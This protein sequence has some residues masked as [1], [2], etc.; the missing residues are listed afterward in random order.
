MVS[1]GACE[2]LLWFCV[3]SASRIRLKWLALQ[4]KHYQGN[5]A[6]SEQKATLKRLCLQAK[7][8]G[9]AVNGSRSL[10]VS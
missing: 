1:A 7:A 5:A 3:V 4:A 9:E 2:C 6:I 8:V 10:V